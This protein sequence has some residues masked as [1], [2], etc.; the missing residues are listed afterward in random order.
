MWLRNAWQAAATWLWITGRSMKDPFSHDSDHTYMIALS[1]KAC[2][3]NEH[4]GTNVMAVTSLHW[5][6]SF[7]ESSGWR[8][9]RLDWTGLMAKAESRVPVS[10]LNSLFGVS[11]V[12]VS[13]TRNRI[14]AVAHQ[15]ED[16]SVLSSKSFLIVLACTWHSSDMLLHPNRNGPVS[17]VHCMAR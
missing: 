3:L 9:Q 13:F 8:A 11:R 2:F 16:L 4:Y 6:M 14:I 5:P 10:H 12:A 7:L 15:N 1:A 17:L